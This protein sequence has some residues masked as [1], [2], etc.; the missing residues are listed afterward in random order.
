MTESAT[1][2]ICHFTM[3][4]EAADEDAYA[5]SG[6]SRESCHGAGSDHKPVHSEKENDHDTRMAE[7][8]GMIRAHMKFDIAQN[9]NGCHAMARKILKKLR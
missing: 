7:G 9:C 6:P 3:V 4:K 8:L 5:D 1:C 2:T